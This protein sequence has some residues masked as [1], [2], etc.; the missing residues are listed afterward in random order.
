MP[1][2]VLFLF[3]TIFLNVEV[4][5]NFTLRSREATSCVTSFFPVLSDGVLRT[6]SGD[7][8]D[9]D[10]IRGDPKFD[11]TPC[12]TVFVTAHFIIGLCVQ[13]RPCLFML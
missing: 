5:Y 7:T 8:A 11:C 6:G 10:V 1:K 12:S 4:S 2:C 3:L 13:F 9:K